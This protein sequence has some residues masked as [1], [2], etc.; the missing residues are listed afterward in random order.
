MLRGTYFPLPVSEKKVLKPCTKKK[1][2]KKKKT[3]HHDEWFVSG[4]R[5]RRQGIKG[6]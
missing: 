4:E 5:K 3:H 6:C 1:K 2:K